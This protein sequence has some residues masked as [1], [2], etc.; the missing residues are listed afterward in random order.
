MHQTTQ[1]GQPPLFAGG[2]DFG[3][4]SGEMK[5]HKQIA[6]VRGAFSHPSLL[7][8]SSHGP[9]QPTQPCFLLKGDRGLYLSLGTAWLVTG[10]E[11]PRV[12]L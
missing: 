12:V 3:A 5:G 4:H 6:Q 11:G 7:G 10:M 8:V 1:G 9:Q 2:C